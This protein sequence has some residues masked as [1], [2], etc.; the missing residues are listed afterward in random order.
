MGL[1]GWD[2]DELGVCVTRIAVRLG[3]PLPRL[4]A[5]WFSRDD[6]VRCPEDRRELLSIPREDLR[7]VEEA[8]IE[9]EELRRLASSS[10]I[11]LLKLE[12]K[13]T[14]GPPIFTPGGLTVRGLGPGS[15][16]KLGVRRP[17]EKWG[18]LRC[19]WRSLSIF[20]SHTA[21]L[22]KIS[23]TA[24]RIAGSMSVTASNRGLAKIF[25]NP[26][27]DSPSLMRSSRTGGPPNRQ[28]GISSS[29]SMIP[30]LLNSSVRML[31]HFAAVSNLR[32]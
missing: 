11:T 2:S 12:V 16:V 26:I 14:R 21:L 32:A 9:P 19:L 17:S 30:W 8:L 29:C 3:S 10:D 7:D 25:I 27:C 24:K 4:D 15:G 23:S 20:F 1:C 13:G 31:A 5:L 22:V 28:D 18:V 6:K